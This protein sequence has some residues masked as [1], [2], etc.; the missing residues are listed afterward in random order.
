VFLVSIRILPAFYEGVCP[1]DRQPVHHTRIVHVNLVSRARMVNM[2]AQ[3]PMER[4]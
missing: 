1:C 3:P 2:S 4:S